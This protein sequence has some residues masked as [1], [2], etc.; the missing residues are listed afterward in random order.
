MMAAQLREKYMQEYRKALFYDIVMFPE[1][2]KYCTGVLI[3][4]T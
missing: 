4:I 3:I 1:E 2:K